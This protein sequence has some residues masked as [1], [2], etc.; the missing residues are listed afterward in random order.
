[1]VG[2]LSKVNCIKF[3]HFIAGLTFVIHIM[4]WLW[5]YLNAFAASGYCSIFTAFKSMP[6][7]SMDFGRHLSNFCDYCIFFRRFFL[8]Y[9]LFGL[10]IL[11]QLFRIIICVYV[12]SLHLFFEVFH[13]SFDCQIKHC[14]GPQYT[15]T[16][17]RIVHC[18]DL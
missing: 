4:L 10:F 8:V 6:Y 1:M 14:I 11:W 16:H 2:R 17:A 12:F 5:D 9:L 15:R 3:N 7:E 18:I 13:E